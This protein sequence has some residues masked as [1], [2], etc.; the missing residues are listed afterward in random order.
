M[1]DIPKDAKKPQDRKAKAEATGEPLRVEYEGHEY[2]ID[3]EAADNIE[4]M[5]FVED[6]KYLSAIRGYLGREQWGVFKDSVRD[7]AGRVPAEKFSEFS[8][9]IYAAMGNLNASS[10]S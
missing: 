5:E 3:R 4:L 7:A 10:G 2:V 6:E 8:E 1:P 9:L